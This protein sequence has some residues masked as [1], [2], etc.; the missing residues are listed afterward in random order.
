MIGIVVITLGFT[1]V[2]YQRIGALR[3]LRDQRALN[4]VNQTFTVLFNQPNVTASDIEKTFDQLSRAMRYSSPAMVR[5][6][7]LSLQVGWFDKSIQAFE[8][9]L[10]A[11]PR[12]INAQIQL[13]YAHALKQGGKLL[14]EP[15]QKAQALIA[16]D[17]KLYALRNIV[18]IHAYLSGSYLEAIEHW[19]TLLMEDKS[20]IPERRAIIEKAI[21]QSKAL[22][23]ARSTTRFRVKLDIAP[24]LRQS[25]QPTDTVFIAVKAAEL[26][27]PPL[28]VM[29]C[30]V[31]DLP[32][33]FVLDD[34]NAMIE[35]PNFGKIHTVEV[36]ARQGDSIRVS[37]GQFSVQQ[38]DNTVSLQLSL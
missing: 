26:D 20:L 29:K 24:A 30:W 9:A 14:P 38:G 15:L 2:T 12:N 36:I 13:I 18:A 32:Q 25:L 19:Q 35:T 23:G 22:L 21:M 34:R 16:Q 31:R 10:L 6:G 11:D 8:T 28:Y 3:G 5:L 1:A 27:M 37:S 4:Q 17:P 7:E 33:E